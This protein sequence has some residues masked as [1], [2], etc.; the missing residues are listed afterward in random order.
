VIS[1]EKPHNKRVGSRAGRWSLPESCRFRVW[2]VA[3]ADPAAAGFRR[4]RKTLCDLQ[5]TNSVI[6]IDFVRKS[7]N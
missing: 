6:L 3:L 7:Q 4:T 1:F 2:S 5:K